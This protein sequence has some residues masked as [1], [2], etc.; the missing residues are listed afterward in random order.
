MVKKMYVFLILIIVI[1][2][3]YYFRNLGRVMQVNLDVAPGIRIGDKID[4]I[5][6][7]KS[8]RRIKTSLIDGE[9]VCK[10]YAGSFK[11]TTENIKLLDKTGEKIRIFYFSF[12]RDLI[13]PGD[14][15]VDYPGY[16]EIP[17]DVDETQLERNYQI[18]WLLKARVHGFAYLPVSVI[19]E[20]EVKALH[21]AAVEVSQLGLSVNGSSCERNCFGGEDMEIKPGRE[22]DRKN[23]SRFRYLELEED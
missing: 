3:F 18:R 14:T 15:L 7:I 5:I 19:K 21:P 2:F 13:I 23:V 8:G 22:Y 11:P 6:K 1:I 16:I 10:R 4:F 12:G 20:I 17:Q 9:L